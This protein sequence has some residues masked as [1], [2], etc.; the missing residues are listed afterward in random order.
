MFFCAEVPGEVAHGRVERRLRDAHH[1]VVRHGA[2]A[3]EVGH[4]QDRAA[5][6]RLHQRLGRARAGDER[7][8]AHVERHPEA[9]ARRVGEAALEI[10]GGGERDRVDEQVELAA[11]RLADLARRRARRRRRSGRR[12]RSRAGSTTDSASSR[13][14]FSIRSPWNVNA[15][16][17]ALVGE[18][19]RDRPRDR[20]PVRDAQH[21]RRACPRTSR[22]RRRVYA[23]GSRN[24]GYSA[25][26]RRLACP[27]PRRGARL[28]RVRRGRAPAGRRD[29]GELEVPRVRAGTLSRPARRTR[30]GRVTRASSACAQPPLA[31]VAP[32]ARRARRAR[33]GSTSAAGSS[34]A[35]LA[36]LAAAQ[37]A[38]VA[39]LRARS[40]RPR[41]RGATA[42]LL[43]GFAVELPARALPA[44]RRQLSFATQGLPELPLHARARPQPGADRRARARARPAAA[45][46]R[47]SRS[48]SSTTASTRRTR[49]SPR[50]ASRTRPASRR[51]ARS[52]RRR[53]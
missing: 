39:P 53:R 46:A 8:G 45:T 27:R 41:S 33:A 23:S 25:A 22:P 49:S 4:R 13:T 52:G 32:D 21:E 44:L 38:A 51:A 11:E 20:A 30:A 42:I 26:V 29:F 18:P 35:Y 12:T 28:G 5:A 48:R 9:V 15:S 3:A 36:R 1:V 24:A 19:L 34:R 6:A 43:N 31:R 40:P 50:P 10:L 16:S 37:R 2:L 17:R 47:A 14:F 7:V